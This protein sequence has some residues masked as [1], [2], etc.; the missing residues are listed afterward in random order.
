MVLLILSTGRS[1]GGDAVFFKKMI[2]RGKVFVWCDEACVYEAVPPQ[3]QTRAYYIK[4]AF[5]RGLTEA[6]E[7]RVFSPGT[8]RSLVAIPLYTAALPFLWLLG[9]HLF[10]RYLVKD[11]DHLAKILGFIGIKVVSER[12]YEFT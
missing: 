11:C 4:R 1:G 12:P 9:Q 2:Q 3:R 5:T 10:M 8:L 7:T 6:W